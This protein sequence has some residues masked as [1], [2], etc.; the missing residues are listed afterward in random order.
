MKN[1]DSCESWIFEFCG[2][3]R[4]KKP[5]SRLALPR[6]NWAGKLF[7]SLGVTFPKEAVVFLEISA[8]VHAIFYTYVLLCASPILH[9]S[10]GAICF[11][12][13]GRVNYRQHSNGAVL[14]CWAMSS[15]ILSNPIRKGTVLRKKFPKTLK[16]PM[17]L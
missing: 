3:K 6:I 15:I 17:L 10:S 4:K 13:Y 7:K 9:F 2:L 1:L 5:M 12:G 16:T 8:I 14:V 11:R